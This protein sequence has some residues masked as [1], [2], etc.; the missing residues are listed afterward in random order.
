MC[1]TE[2]KGEVQSDEYA[3]TGGGHPHKNQNKASQRGRPGGNEV[4][5]LP[6]VGNL[7][8]G[9]KKNRERKVP[10]I[11]RR[12]GDVIEKKGGEK[13]I[14]G[15]E[16]RVEYHR[17]RKKK[18][19][20][21]RE[22]V[23]KKWHKGRAGKSICPRKTKLSGGCLLS[24]SLSKGARALEGIRAGYFLEQ[25]PGKAPFSPSQGKER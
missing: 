13:G 4:V 25:S 19:G 23:W 15:H 8:G 7:G 21:K 18:K 22:G 14:F 17:R 3:I 9:D 24:S 6:R 5:H 10:W 11:H 1:K 2:K 16:A 20:K 12:D